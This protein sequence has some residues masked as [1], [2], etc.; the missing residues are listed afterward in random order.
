M[1]TEVIVNADIHQEPLFKGDVGYIDGYVQA[2]DGRP[3]A[4]VIT[5]KFTIG[6][7][8]IYA[9]IPTGKFINQ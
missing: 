3:Y 6:F 1:K 5:Y 9:L 2:G 4:I 7:A 8:P